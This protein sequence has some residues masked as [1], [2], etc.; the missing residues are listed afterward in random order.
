SCVFEF[1]PEEEADTSTTLLCDK[2][3]EG[4][5]YR[6]LLTAANGL[7]RY[8]INDLI[9]VTG[10]HHRCP[11]VRFLRKGRDMTS[12]TGEKMHVNH[13]LSAMQAVADGTG[14][15]ARAFRFVANIRANRYDIYAESGN[16]HP[17]PD[18]AEI[19]DSALSRHNLEYA[20]KRR[21]GQLR[22]PNLVAMRPGWADAVCR[23]AAD[24]GRRD[25]EFK[26]RHL[27]DQPDPVDRN[28]VRPLAPRPAGAGAHASRLS[29]AS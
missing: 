25:I 3:E 14:F 1:L 7:Y 24:S 2:L 4:G 18:L 6:V 17:H 19:I 26:W 13:C 16:S 5:R 9:E 20:K 8:D 15:S 28:F 29:L 11:L 21:S 23:A 22:A 27:S 10:F 12:I